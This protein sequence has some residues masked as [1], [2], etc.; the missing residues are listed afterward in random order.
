MTTEANHS[1][2]LGGAV[3][4]N[5]A[6]ELEAMGDWVVVV[7]K[8]APELHSAGKTADGREVHI[9]LPSTAR[10]KIEAE[11]AGRVVSIG[12][13]AAIKHPK[14]KLGDRIAYTRVFPMNKTGSKTEI[15]SLVHKDNIIARLKSVTITPGMAPETDAF[16]QS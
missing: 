3:H 2:Q 14:L 9:E 11:Y 13:D 7:R 4:K 10:D 6:E 8:T 1:N 12:D 15:Y 16:R 5:E